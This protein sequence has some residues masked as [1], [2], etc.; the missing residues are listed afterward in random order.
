[1]CN[2]VKT[3]I[4]SIN[5]GVIVCSA[6]FS[7]I[8]SIEIGTVIGSAVGRVRNN[9]ASV[10]NGYLGYAEYIIRGLEASTN[11]NA[12]NYSDIS[13][14]NTDKIAYYNLAGNVE[15]WIRSGNQSG[16]FTPA[17]NTVYAHGFDATQ[18]DNRLMASNQTNMPVTLV[19]MDNRLNPIT[20]PVGS[21][22]VEIERSRYFMLNKNYLSTGTLSTIIS[23]T[24]NVTI[25]VYDYNSDVAN[26]TALNSEEE[27]VVPT[28]QVFR[29]SVRAQ[30]QAGN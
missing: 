14:A 2:I 9:T 18:Y 22:N 12:N 23:P 8:Y 16:A 27:I 15:T 7:E 17:N 3:E 21:S 6:P 25:T 1:M 28:R 20:I 19:Y 5:N 13:T 30:I 4:L 26:E 24:I 10:I 11:T 29:S